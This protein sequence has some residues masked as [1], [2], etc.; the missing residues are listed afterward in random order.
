MPDLELRVSQFLEKQLRRQINI[1]DFAKFL[2]SNKL[3][4]PKKVKAVIKE[5]EGKGVILYDSCRCVVVK[6]LA[7]GK[8]I[9]DGTRAY[10]VL[11]QQY[12][13]L[14]N[15]LPGNARF[16][17]FNATP[18]VKRIYDAIALLRQVYGEKFRLS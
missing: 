15:D 17:Y 14:L 4:K 3:C 2:S 9:Y 8:E 12:L 6:K 11:G 13:H 5:L 7:D 16:R 10:T 1:A 18:E